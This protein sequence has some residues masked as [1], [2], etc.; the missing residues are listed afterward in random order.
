MAG[1]A[2]ASTPPPAQRCG[3]PAHPARVVSFRT[4]DGVRLAGAIVG[5]GPRGV[6]LVHESGRLALCGWWPYAARLAD[7][8]FHVLLFDLR[9][10]GLS[11]CPA[12]GADAYVA[13]VAAAAATLRR[14]GCRSVELVGASAGGSIALVATARLRGIAAVADLSGDGLDLPIGG[15]GR[16]LTAR[17]AAP[18]VR[19]P[20]LLAVARNDP[21][22]G[23]ADV[24]ALGRRAGSAEKRLVVL[25]AGAG[26]GWD[27]VRPPG[28]RWSPFARTLTAFL[29]RHAMP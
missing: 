6:V 28:G 10:A 24:R 3:A 5:T 1:P 16:P 27:L 21:Y 15:G 9:C 23:L 13:D 12:R 22:V 8:G 19:A 25:P 20:L 7:R 18:A 17:Q 4:A 29:A 14:P 11:G 26:H 2:T